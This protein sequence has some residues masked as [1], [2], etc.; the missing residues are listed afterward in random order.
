M[1]S[2]CPFLTGGGGGGGPAGVL[3]GGGGG[4]PR[5]SGSDDPCIL[6][7]GGGGGAS[8]PPFRISGGGGGGAAIET[9]GSGQI[10][11]REQPGRWPSSSHGG[12]EQNSIT[13]ERSCPSLTPSF[14]QT[15][16]QL[17][18]PQSGQRSSASCRLKHPQH[19]L[20]RLLRGHCQLSSGHPAR[21]AQPSSGQRGSPCSNPAVTLSKSQ[22]AGHLSGSERPPPHH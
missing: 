14:P 2:L 13:T 21:Q 10:R 19:W 9:P 7:G 4:F 16:A 5:L 17:V 12:N 8:R 6:Y 22:H 11:T 20:P 15:L 3:V 1:E 18:Q